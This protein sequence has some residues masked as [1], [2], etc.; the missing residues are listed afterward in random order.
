MD[1]HRFG[2]DDAPLPSESDLGV[3]ETRDE[4]QRKPSLK[5][6]VRKT[7]LV[8][9]LAQIPPWGQ[10]TTTAEMLGRDRRNDSTVCPHRS[11]RPT[12][13]VAAYHHHRVLVKLQR[14]HI[15]A[16]IS[17]E[18]PK[19][20]CQPVQKLAPNAAR[21]CLFLNAHLIRGLALIGG[22]CPMTTKTIRRMLRWH[23]PAETASQPLKT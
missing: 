17:L 19:S 11:L 4:Q 23:T 2:V 16:E 3:H 6:A 12:V 15:P 20:C 8:Q 22:I 14:R 5:I 9:W 10:T 1:A 21:H 18:V 13:L 7:F